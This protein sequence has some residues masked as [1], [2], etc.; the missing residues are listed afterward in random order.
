MFEGLADRLGQWWEG[1]SAMTM[2]RKIVV[3]AV[4]SMAL[5]G[6]IVLM[7]WTNKTDYE[8]VYS[9]LSQEDAGAII[10]KLKEKK[11]PFL[12]EAN[13]TAIQVPREVMEETRLLLATEGL[14]AGGAV[15]YEI[16]NQI[17]I[18]TT[19]FVQ[20]LNFQRA[21]QGELERT[22]KK[23][24]EVD[25]VR[26]HLNIPKESLFIEEAR[27]PSASVVLKFSSGRSLTRSQLEGVVHLVASS[28]EG[29]KPQ[30]I[31]IV[32]TTGGL[33]YSKEDENQQGLLTDSQVQYRRN[34]EKTLADRATSMLERIV[35][36]GKALTRVSADLDYTRISTDEEIYDPDRSG[37]RSEQRTKETSSGQG[38]GASGV[39]TER[40]DLGTRAPA[41]GAQGSA[42]ETFER[43]D[44]TTNYEVT[45]INR[46]TL[47]PGGEIKRLT[48]AVM[49]DGTYQMTEKDG[50]KVSTFVPR[51]QAELTRLEDLVRN[52]VGYSGA[53]NDS[54]VVQS[55]PFYLPEKIGE[56]MMDRVFEYLGQYGRTAFNI[57]LIVLFFLFVARPMINWIREESAAALPAPQPLEE[58]PEPEEREALE[59][60]EVE[61]GRITREQVQAIAQQNPERTLNLLRSWIDQR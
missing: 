53:R 2:A 26:V 37:V 30:N 47:S 7:I 56:S 1:F 8:V 39:P 40:Y 49:V 34:L 21:L 5:A 18:G 12:L 29:L 55:V 31:S 19:D 25:Q 24:R 35:G 6:F 32:D 58:L 3:L 20:R 9:G 27:E 59:Q 60:P 22:I 54:V 15:G 41:T 46:R 57:I 13:G 43:S 23:F 11:V 50:Q 48:V 14:P 51:D 33:L 4:A 17:S 38:Q 10:A 52:A 42:K 44:E 61:K 45:K 36:P 16:F 28:V